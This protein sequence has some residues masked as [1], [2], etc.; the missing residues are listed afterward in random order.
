[1]ATVANITVNPAPNNPAV[2]VVNLSGEID[3]SNLPEFENVVN[4]LVQDLNN[5]VLIFN[6]KGLEFISSKVIGHFAYLYTTLK[7]SQRKIILADLDQDIKDIFALVGLDQ[8]IASYPTLEEAL[9]N[10]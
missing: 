10:F 5:K 8:M 6:L 7:H 4:P 2:K 3:E 9:R 1:M